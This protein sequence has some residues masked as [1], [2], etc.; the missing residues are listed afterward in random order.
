MKKITFLL[1]VIILAFVNAAMAQTATTDP[2]VFINGIKW[3]TR[4]VGEPGMF[5]D[6][7]G[8]YGMLYRWNSNVAW[9]TTPQGD[10][11]PNEKTVWNSWNGSNSTTW[12][13]TNNVCP[14]G[15]R[16]PTG[17]EL[18]ILYNSPNEWKYGYQSAYGSNGRIFGTGNNTIFLPAAGKRNETGTAGETG[19]YAH[20]WSSTKMTGSI[21]AY[22]LYFWTTAAFQFTASSAANAHSV[23]CV[24]D[25]EYNYDIPVSSI[26]LDVTSYIYLPLNGTKTLTATVLPANATNKTVTWS[27]DNTAVASVDANGKITAI[28][29]GNTIIT[30]QAGN[31]TITCYVGV[32]VSS[33]I[34]DD[35]GVIIN[36]IKWATRN[37]DL[38][39]TFTANPEDYGLYYQWGSNVG[40]TIGNSY[41]TNGDYEWVDY[42]EKGNVWTIE[43]DPCPTGWR[44]PT[45]KEFED[46]WKSGSEWVI[47]ND[48][49][50]RKFGSGDNTIFLPQAGLSVIGH[51]NSGVYWSSNSG[52]FSDQ[53]SCL[54]F[55]YQSLGTTG[56]EIR[57]AGL[58]V[59]CVADIPPSTNANLQSL[60]VFDAEMTPAFNADIT[61]YTIIVPF[62][63]NY[64]EGYFYPADNKAT[65]NGSDY[66]KFYQN[67]RIGK[68]IV[69]IVVTAEDGITQKTYT[70]EVTREAMEEREEIINITTPGTL[71]S[72]LFVDFSSRP[73]TKLTITGDIDVRDIYFLDSLQ[74]LVNLDMGNANIVA[75]EGEVN[76]YG[77]NYID[78]RF[79]PANELPDDT[80]STRWIGSSS[81]SYYFYNTQYLASI[82]LP[83]TLTSIGNGVLSSHM[84]GSSRDLTS[85]HIPEGVTKIGVGCFI[86]QSAFTSVTLPSTLT[87]I[88][89]DSFLYCDN[90]SIVINHN[91][92]PI[93]IECVFTCS[94][95]EGNPVLYVP[96][97]SGDLYREATIWKLFNIVELPDLS[98][99]GISVIPSE[100]GAFIVWQPN[101]AAEGYKLMIYADEERTE[102]IRTLEFDATG[103][104]INVTEHRVKG[105][106]Q[107]EA[108][109]FTYTIEDLLNHTTY[110]YTLETLGVLNTILTQQNGQFTTATTSLPS[111][112]APSNNV[113]SINKTIIVE[114]VSGQNITVYNISGQMQIQEKTLN[115]TVKMPVSQSGVYLVSIN[116]KIQKVIVK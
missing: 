70:L 40:W 38:P 54:I 114:N 109:S 14:Q 44:I 98:E 10:L 22:S 112:K 111:Q 93:A 35:E 69:V 94:T 20:Y 57:Q 101:D 1:T 71:N 68:N 32:L 91:H 85:I 115:E 42:T 87:Q 27:S 21:S 53:A 79:Y 56:F 15:W 39:G 28:G 65:V 24:A 100:N 59:R 67:L 52:D 58:S 55:N 75:Y 45:T 73:I 116:G 84:P 103:W 11:F 102:L 34:T 60:Y 99:D 106:I 61:N 64:I 29:G 88:G 50:G 46:L 86:G 89:G 97:G 110:Y 3:A 41:S 33:N 92:N 47:S 18:E 83:K 90:L 37:V 43:K 104:L 5:V 105:K 107:T 16:I 25:I 9:S 23:R 48:F 31:K 19:L 95:L 30:A 13:T 76:V 66:F 77:G 26:S 36:N 4:N 51:G 82:V 7:P 49:A 80:F 12:E 78:S 6:N 113:Y 108:A 72:T 62:E 63:E 8:D 74:Y 2:G 81:G 17:T 96:F